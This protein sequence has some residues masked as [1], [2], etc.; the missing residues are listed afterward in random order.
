M[1]LKI[2]SLGLLSSTLLLGASESVQV[3]ARPYYLID[4][5]QNKTLKTK[6]Q[7]CENQTFKRTNFSIG[8]RGACM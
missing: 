4:K 5:L 7:K 8:H 1:K 6:L 2:I 3:G